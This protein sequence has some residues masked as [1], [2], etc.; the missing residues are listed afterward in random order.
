ML[1]ETGVNMV[2]V[3]RGCIGNPWVF[4]QARAMLHNQTPLPPTIHQQRDV[5]REHF[6]LSIELHDEKQASKMMRKFGIRF[7]RHHPA[8]EAVKQAFIGVAS[9]NDWSAVLN[10]FYADDGP[11]VDA[12]PDEAREIDQSCDNAT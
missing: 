2:S 11:G 7:A 3:A 8:A 1:R 6:T 9:L 5:L 4:T 12:L 10:T